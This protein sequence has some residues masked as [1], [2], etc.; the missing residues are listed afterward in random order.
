[1][2]R[3]ELRT[4]IARN[5]RI[6]S[7][8]E[9]T[10]IE[11]S[12]ITVAG[13]NEEI[14][15]VYRNTLAQLL[16][17]KYPQDFEQ[18][19]YPIRTYRESF[20]VSAS[21]TG[22][23]LISTSEVFFNGD[24]GFKIQNP[25]TGETLIV[26][27]YN[28]TTS[29]TTT[30]DVPATWIGDTVYILGNILR[31]NG[32]LADFREIL[33]VKI[34]FASSENRYSVAELVRSNDYEPMKSDEFNKNAPKYILS[35]LKT[36]TGNERCLRFLPDFNDYTGTV[37]IKYTQLPPKLVS[38]SD[39]PILEIIGIEDAII[40]GVTSWGFRILKDWDSSTAY[41]KILGDQINIMLS[42]YKP[43]N[44]DTTRRQRTQAF[45][46]QMRDRIA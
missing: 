6:L 36:A 27:T 29:V 38:D 22:S 14:N 23:T 26:E 19:S 20:T 13:I 31:L 35:T 41:Q 15:K 40:A 1:M 11:G 16:I 21:T 7:S 3:E 42:T 5:L 44:K 4:A 8:D 37:L 33:S 25:S 17:N 28:S 30:E 18:W 43:R 45:Y 9:T 32:E 2:D 12:G 39:I 10:V 34:K 46:R 24:E